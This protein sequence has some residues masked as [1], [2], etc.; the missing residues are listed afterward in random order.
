MTS[1]CPLAL[2][3]RQGGVSPRRL[4]R[5]SGFLVNRAFVHSLPDL[6][7]QSMITDGRCLQ[8][9]VIMDARNRA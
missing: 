7:R 3:S 5:L 4:Q 9:A 2:T 6:F 8:L 1:P